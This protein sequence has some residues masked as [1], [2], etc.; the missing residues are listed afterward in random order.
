[1]EKNDVNFKIR[2]NWLNW[3]LENVNSQ[4]KENLFELVTQ[5][6]IDCSINERAANLSR[7]DACTNPAFKQKK[8]C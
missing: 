3:K 8:Q 6:I 1:M 4:L 7:N 5:L 2:A